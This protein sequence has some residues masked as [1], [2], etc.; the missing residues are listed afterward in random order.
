MKL[1]PLITLAL[2]LNTFTVNTLASSVVRARSLATVDEATKRELL[3]LLPRD[4]LPLG[5][6]AIVLCDGTGRTGDC[7]AYLAAVATCNVS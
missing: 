4:P 6:S 5:Q 3:N 2:S 7:E 1:L